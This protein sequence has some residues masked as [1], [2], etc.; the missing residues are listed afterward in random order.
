[1]IEIIKINRI[2]ENKF[3]IFLSQNGEPHSFTINYLK[4][5]IDSLNEF[6]PYIT[7]EDRSFDAFWNSDLP[8][9]QNLMDALKIAVA[10][11]QK[12]SV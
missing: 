1:M 10:Q 11:N 4:V 9:R 3:D 12:Q 2:N 5:W 6:M 7:A 8:F